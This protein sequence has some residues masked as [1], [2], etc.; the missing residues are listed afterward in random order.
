MAGTDLLDR[1]PLRTLI[2]ALH[3]GLRMGEVGV[4][5]ARPGTGKTALVVQFA[6]ERLLRGEPVLHLSIHDS[7]DTNRDAYDSL[8][9][10]L[11]GNARPIER[12][13]ARI[14]IE[15]HRM[16]HYTRGSLPT[17]ASIDALLETLDL[18]VEFKPRMVIIDGT[19]PTTGE[20]DA[21]K[22]MADRRELAIWYAVRSYPETAGLGDVSIELVPERTHG[23][24]CQRRHRL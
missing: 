8:L 6:L 22:A 17:A 5:R 24:I 4:V 19:E 11:A 16:I 12:A 2:A 9:A 18:A 7:I 20:W 10:G 15:R 3:G 21:I 23:W 13:E 14:Q 1:G